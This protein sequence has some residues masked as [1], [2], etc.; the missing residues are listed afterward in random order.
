MQTIYIGIFVDFFFVL[1][2]DVKGR[3]VKSTRKCTDAYLAER[4]ISQFKFK[5]T[6]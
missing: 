3:E 2:F 4:Q 5:T 6:D 1:Y